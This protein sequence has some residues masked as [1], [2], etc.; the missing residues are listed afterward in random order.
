MYSIVVDFCLI[1]R[2]KIS[3]VIDFAIMQKLVTMLVTEDF[4]SIWKHCIKKIIDLM[5]DFKMK[6]EINDFFSIYGHITQ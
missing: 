4:C 3:D 6:I 2:V 5:A 1:I